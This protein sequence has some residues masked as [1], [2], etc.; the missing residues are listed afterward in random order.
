MYN[1]V[2][3]YPIDYYRLQ[4]ALGKRK[5]TL[6]SAASKLGMSRSGLSN[7][8]NSGNI[9]SQTKVSL[10]QILGI[11]YDEIKPLNPT[12]SSPSSVECKFPD[13][14]QVYISDEQMEQLQVIIG[15][16][17]YKAVHTALNEPGGSGKED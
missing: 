10:E 6:Q 1:K 5:L 11:K 14:L 7:S 13:K 12:T 2:G 4:D 16:A 9:S 3:R 8:K 17:V 15:R